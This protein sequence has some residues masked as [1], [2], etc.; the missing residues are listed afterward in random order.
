[1][2]W[3]ILFFAASSLYAAMPAKLTFGTEIRYREEFLNNFNL[4]FYGP[5]P[6]KGKSHSEFLL[7]RVRSGFDYTPNNVIH[8]A[9][10]GQ[11]ARDWGTGFTDSD[12]YNPI[13]GTENNP[14]KDEFELWNS[15][16]EIKKPADLPFAVK[17]GRQQIYYG[18]KRVFGPGQWGNSGK[19]MWDAVKT[20]IF[21]PKGFIDIYYGRTMIHN[22]KEFSLNHRH[23][24]ESVGSYAHITLLEKMG[25]IGVEPFA[26]TKYDSHKRYK[27]EDGK[28]GDLK[29]AYAGIRVYKK[30]IHGFDL[31][32]LYVREF[33]DLADDVVQAYGYHLL[34]AYTFDRCPYRPR[35]SLEYS[36]G[37]GDKNPNDGKRETFDGAYGARDK[38]YGRMNLFRWRN[39]RDLQMNL[40]IRPKRWKWIYLKAE[41]HKFWLDS[42]KAGWSLN[43][44]RY[45]DKTGNS[46]NE[47]GEEFDIVCRFNLPKGHQIQTGYGHF[48]PDEFA[49]KLASNKQ[50]NW[51]F[52]QWQYKF[53][54]RIF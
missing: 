17:A 51:F 36:V 48:W 52:V 9:L 25:G 27:G 13:F 23:G 45:R 49:K 38:M 8:I 26:M 35:I 20:S 14:Y 32:V 24:F 37:S 10:W 15:Y 11:D 2:I 28:F 53:K 6:P 31:D 46:G 40:E 30:N 22:P 1:M 5:H 19:W 34:G 4:A 18:D 33:G 3:A 50:A 39:I 29:A 7:Q 12:F 44:K 16:L 21:I 47:V 41:L 54:W 43:P 42:K